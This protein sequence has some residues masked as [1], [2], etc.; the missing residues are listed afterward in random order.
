MQHMCSFLRRCVAINSHEKNGEQR[1]Y[2]ENY[3]NRFSFSTIEL[4]IQ[5]AIFGR[6]EVGVELFAVT[7]RGSFGLMLV[8]AR[9]GNLRKL[10]FSKGFLLIALRCFA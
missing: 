3:R 2:Q 5:W 1:K 9:E 4:A 8:Q 7:S 6:K 10:D